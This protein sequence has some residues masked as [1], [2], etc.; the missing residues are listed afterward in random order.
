[1]VGFH[2]LWML[3]ILV[4]VAVVVV[5]V[6]VVVLAVNASSRTAH[7]IG[8][9]PMQ[10]GVA[11]PPPPRETPLEILA[12]RFAAGEISADEYERARDLLGGGGK[13]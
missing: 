1:M 10:I 6:M 8:A 9:P 7:P 11:P 12:R 5:I 2:F 3:F 4:P 13:T